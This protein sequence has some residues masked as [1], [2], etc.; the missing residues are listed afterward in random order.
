MKGMNSSKESETQQSYFY[1]VWPEDKSPGGAS[2]AAAIPSV[3]ATSAV[4]SSNSSSSATQPTFNYESQALTTSSSCSSS[5]SLQQESPVE[6]P[7]APSKDMA[8]VQV[9]TTINNRT[10][11]SQLATDGSGIL[12]NGMKSQPVQHVAASVPSSAAVSSSTLNFVIPSLD[13]FT[14]TTS[15]GRHRTMLTPDHSSPGGK[16][17]FHQGV[18]VNSGGDSNLR[19]I[20]MNMHT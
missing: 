20:G 2:V 9:M 11:Q 8:S 19:E 5:S 14:A 12:P 16:Q 17:K 18:A 7:L 15:V 10:S 6:S 3:A 13:S 4:I 1:V